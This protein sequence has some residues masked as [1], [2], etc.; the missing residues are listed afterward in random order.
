MYSRIKLLSW[1]RIT[2]F[3]VFVILTLSPVIEWGFSW[4]LLAALLFIFA[5]KGSVDLLRKK[6]GVRPSRRSTRVWKRLLTAVA[7]LISLIP[8]I[9]FPQYR[10][11]EVTG[12]YEV[13][14]AVYTYTDPNRVEEF[15]DTGERRRVNV[16]F[17]YP[18]HAEGKYPLIVFSHGAYG[19]RESNASTFTEL[20]SHGYVVAS[21][22]HPYHSFYTQSVDG[23]VT[24][25]N[26]DY[27]REVNDSNK[28]GIYTMEELYGLTQKWMKLRTGDMNL[29]I[30]HILEKAASSEDPVYQL[31][32][33]EHIG[34]IGHSMGGAASVAL[35]RERSDV[36]AVVNLDAPFFTELVYDRKINDLAAK[37]EPY[38]VPLLNIYTDDVWRQLG[39]NSAYAANNTGNPNFKDAYTVHFVG[40]KHLSLTDLPLFSPILANMLQRGQADIDK[41]YCIETMNKL[42]LEFYDYTL[43]G[44]GQFAPQAVY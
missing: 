2:L 32:D 16:K 42:I 7:L 22:D 4:G 15:T 25:I 5:L 43:K 34:V 3:I 31:I 40:A 35:G 37:D 39:K 19:V 21:V 24:M 30:D 8:P 44:I 41:Y 36:D 26:A 14:T 1:I 9:L 10:A 28:D 27:M 20:A 13:R 29:V 11:P 18:V 33:T 17:W 6:T 23:K 38:R 12:E